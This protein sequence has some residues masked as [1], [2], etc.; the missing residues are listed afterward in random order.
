MI[1]SASDS[2][3]ASFHSAIAHLQ[4]SDPRNNAKGKPLKEWA[5]G[6]FGESLRVSIVNEAKQAGNRAKE[7]LSQRSAQHA[8]FIATD[9]DA[10]APL[11]AHC[12]RLVYPGLRTILF[13][14]TTDETGKIDARLILHDGAGA[15]KL[16]NFYK[17]LFPNVALED[18]RKFLGDNASVHSAASES[19][20]AALIV[21]SELSDEDS[22]VK[23]VRALVDDGYAGVIFSG[24]PG[25][26][27]SWYAREMALKLVDGRIDK[28]FFAQFHP[29]YQYEDFIES[30]TPNQ[31]GGFDLTD[32]TFLIACNRAIADPD[33]DVVLVIDELSRTDVVR[34]FGEAL[35]YIESGK[36]ELDFSL[37]SGRIVYVPRNLII[38]AT[39][40]PWDRGADELDLA[41]ERRLAK[42]SF[43][44]DVN[45]L[46]AHLEST[47]LGPDQRA[48]LEQFFLSVARHPN[49]LCQLGHAYFLRA[50]DEDSL[51]RL[52]DNQLYHHFSKVLRNDEE[53]FKSIESSWNR[54][55]QG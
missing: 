10:L 31:S 39:M 12:K 22:V 1:E 29:A 54:I 20:D 14:K 36:R 30:F 45:L 9:E 4:N 23:L 2:R 41:L 40:N 46:K 25:T 42:I 37:P 13:A 55:F 27:K 26:S 47:S 51:K 15:S 24:P 28:V 3:I 5:L 16:E 50:K 43:P 35:T 44:P 34:V 19:T 52:W 18:L 49:R 6:N 38:L 11:I 17:H 7:Q 32:R 8:I 21:N 33:F 53:Q 48:R